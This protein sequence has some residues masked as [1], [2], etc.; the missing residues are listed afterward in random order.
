[1]FMQN[2]DGLAASATRGAIGFPYSRTS[3]MTYVDFRDVAEV[4]ALALTQTRLDNGTFELAAPGMVDTVAIAA[5]FA[6]ALGHPVE[7]REFEFSDWA[8]RQIM[9]DGPLHSGLAR[10]NADYDDHGFHGGN[11]LVLETILGRPPRTLED[12]VREATG[13]K[14]EAVGPRPA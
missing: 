8:S 11:S 12:Y 2:L 5:M 3:Q 4:T 6:A 9:P 14:S 10:M 7:A 1:M 13:S